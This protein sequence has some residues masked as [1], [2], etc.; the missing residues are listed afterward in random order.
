[1]GKE[2]LYD[3]IGEICSGMTLSSIETKA[4]NKSQKRF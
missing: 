3:K 2:G 4:L 1:M